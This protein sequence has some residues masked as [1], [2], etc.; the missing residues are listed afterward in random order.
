MKQIDVLIVGAGMVG[1]TLALALK[2]SAMSVCVLDR[3]SLSVPAFNA[4]TPFAPR[5]S[6]LSLASQRIL[7]NLDVWPGVLARRA[8]PYTR[9]QVWDGSGTGAIHFAA[10]SV[11]AQ[12]LGF[13]VENQ[14]VQAALWEQLKQTA[15]ECMTNCSVHTLVANPQGW[16]VT[17]SDGRILQTTLLVAADG[18]DS[19]IR[20]LAGCATRT[21]AYLHQAIVATVRTSEEH[22]ATAW[23]RFT[24]EGPLAFLP[25]TRGI[26]HNWCSVVWSCIPERAQELMKLED[27]AFAG[28]L[29][30]AFEQ[31]LGAVLE[32]HPRVCIPLKQ[33]HAK[34]YIQPGLALLGDAA[35]SIH[36]LAGQ[37]ANLGF[38]DAAVLAEELIRAQTRGERWSDERVLSRYERRRMPHNL[39][40]MS[41][42]EG[43]ERLFQSTALPARWLRNFG[44]GLV[45]DIPEVKALFIRHALGLSGDLPVLA[46]E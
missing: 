2:G 30:R 45:N 43:L 15:I 16:C 42:M 27:Q 12:Q 3:S 13:I 44:L 26:E 4:E 40:M 33:Q 22:Q 29:A 21:W 5:V 20:Q 35:H 34:R 9:M 25:L 8:S 24:D 46:R 11:H 41:A 7:E 39:A 10:A 14:I 36:P 38:L 31:R 32:V 23:Q 37:G 1:S 17:L 6:A 28:A 18:T 19:Q